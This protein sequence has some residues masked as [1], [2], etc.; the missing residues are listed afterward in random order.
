[1]ITTLLLCTALAQT[2]P[3]EASLP[4][5]THSQAAWADA[6]VGMFIH[7][8]PNTWQD[9]EYDDLS[10]PL[11]KINPEQLDVE[12]W[13][14]TAQSMHAGYIMFVAKHAGGFCWW[15]TATTDYSVKST[16]WKG[17]K[18]DVVAELSAACRAH[19]LEFGLYLSPQD[20]KHGA[21]VG[22]KCASE[23][24][25][26]A[27]EV[28]Y[29]A[30]LT[31]L[32]SRY[33]Q[34]AEVWFDGSLVF[35]VSDILRSHAPDAILFQGPKANIRWVGNEDGV[36]PY[37]CW[38]GAK[39]DAKTWGTLTA[40]DAVPGGDRWLPSECDA[41][42]RSTW[43]WNTHNAP[44]LK[45]VA[46]LMD[47]YE[48]SVGHGAN[49]LLNVTPDPTGRIP[50]ADVARAKE[51]GDEVS[52]RYG[53]ALADT[54]GRG[55]SV[56]VML[57]APK[58][59]GRVVIMEDITQGERIRSYELDG[60]IDGQW[61]KIGEGTAVGHKRIQKFEAVTLSGVRLRVT[62]SVGEAVVRRL[63]VYGVQ[64]EKGPKG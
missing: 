43:F 64:G 4:R 61:K 20:K 46:A 16:P 9:R 12:Q 26:A 7:F 6:E 22:G 59:A 44:T 49:L 5:P 18:G 60:M 25:Q 14:Q 55:P 48:K 40:D 15:P 53:T 39:F 63:A 37:P 32:L 36:A 50:E 41:R 8:A 24:E 58:R 21:A 30:Q 11:D 1:M 56:E 19:G 23:K 33:G 62:G 47:M 13:V 2:P 38:N 31:E 27:Y 29:R 3:P 17:G 10:T 57:S 34:I 51:F 42:M 35:D 28:M 54:S 45:S 52:R